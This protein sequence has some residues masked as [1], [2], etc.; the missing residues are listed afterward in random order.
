VLFKII[1]AEYVGDVKFNHHQKEK[2]HH[3]KH[4]GCHVLIP[5]ACPL[6]RG[7]SQNALVFHDSTWFIPPVLFKIILA[8]YVGDVKFNHHQ[9]E[10]FHHK[11]H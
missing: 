11:K 6:A 2:F 1:L 7:D 3:K 9:K 8:E 10:K 4:Y 5:S